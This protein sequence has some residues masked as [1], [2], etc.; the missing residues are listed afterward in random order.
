MNSTPSFSIRK[1]KDRLKSGLSC[2]VPF[3]NQRP[4]VNERLRSILDQQG[5]RIDELIIIDDASN[6]ETSLAIHDFLK[7]WGRETRID[8]KFIENQENEGILK[9]WK[10]GVL[11]CESPFIWI[12]EGDD[13]C[14]P[15]FLS[16][17]ENDCLNQPE[18]PQ[19]F[20]FD[21][22]VIGPKG[23]IIQMNFGDWYLRQGIPLRQDTQSLE[24]E[25]ILQY[26]KVINIFPNI[27]AMLWSTHEFN[28]CLECLVDD[29]NLKAYLDWA[30]YFTAFSQVQLHAI[31]SPKPKN[32]FRK[33]IGSFSSSLSAE[34]M[35]LE[36][37]ELYKFIDRN[38]EPDVGTRK[39]RK[40][41]LHTIK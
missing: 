29:C 32:L 23:D 19:L 41:Y 39:L 14:T 38:G 6:D 7:R 24:N 40:E 16:T 1:K 31:W 34:E 20:I 37:E 10:K 4:F 5:A 26:L 33:H 28:K 21:S 25:A 30:L 8:I 22:K 9:C 2:L 3:Y 11:S 12:A 36:I 17:W 27:S 18:K 15:D 13:S 35:V